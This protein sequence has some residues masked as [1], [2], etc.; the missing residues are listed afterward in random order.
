MSRP[1]R[2]SRRSTWGT[3]GG[4]VCGT[5]A[6]RHPFRH[7]PWPARSTGA[8]ATASGGSRRARS[9]TGLKPPRHRRP[10]AGMRSRHEMACRGGE[11][12]EASHSQARCSRV[13]RH[14][15]PWRCSVVN[16][17]FFGPL[18]ALPLVLPISGIGNR[19]R[20]SRKLEPLPGRVL[21]TPGSDSPTSFR[22]PAGGVKT[23][24]G[25]TQ[26]AARELVPS[27]HHERSG[28][29]GV[30]L[31]PSASLVFFNPRGD[32]YPALP[33]GIRNRG[34]FST[35]PQ[36]RLRVLNASVEKPDS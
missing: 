28:V 27:L 36:R 34:N 10:R 35:V 6:S 15:L 18:G 8:R 16:P 2:F 9:F 23:S 22:H 7:G 20:T 25:V 24:D 21:E 1:E 30:V 19:G 3:G 14:A 31:L 5:A 32:I 33:C 12:Q 29:H 13:A 4:P 17:P 26:G 11:G